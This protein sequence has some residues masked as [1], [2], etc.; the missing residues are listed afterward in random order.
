ME[1]AKVRDFVKSPKTVHRKNKTIL[2]IDGHERETHSGRRR[3]DKHQAKHKY[4]Y[5]LP[6]FNV[7]VDSFALLIKHITHICLC[8]Q[9][10]ARFDARILSLFF[11]LLPSSWL[12]L[13]FVLS[14]SRITLFRRDF[15]FPLNSVVLFL[16]FCW[17]FVANFQWTP[18]YSLLVACRTAISNG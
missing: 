7:Q 16:L 3:V 1:N 2:E 10:F 15:Y 17:L 12:S 4:P 9:D 18:T 8:T 13:C 5:W 6:K 14:F 11:S